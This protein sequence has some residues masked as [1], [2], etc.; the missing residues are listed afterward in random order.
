MDNLYKAPESHVSDLTLVKTPPALMRIIN[1]I[2][3][4]FALS[5]IQLIVGFVIDPEML[6]LDGEFSIAY[7]IT[8]LAIMLLFWFLV[9]YLC[10]LRPVKNRKRKAA[11]WVFWTTL[12]LMALGVYMEFFSENPEMQVSLLEN[13]LALVETVILF[14]A[15]YL[16]TRPEYKAHLIN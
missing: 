9:Y 3:L 14:Y 10:L 6:T 2:K 7:L 15:A 13:A 16:L 8:L 12:F 1:L 4:A 11:H 5:V